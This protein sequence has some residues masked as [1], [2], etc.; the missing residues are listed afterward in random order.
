MQDKNLSNIQWVLK[1]LKKICKSQCFYYIKTIRK[2]CKNAIAL[3]KF[4][5]FKNTF[6][7]KRTFVVSAKLKENN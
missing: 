6:V 5:Q 4:F 1:N 7:I 2:L 3:L